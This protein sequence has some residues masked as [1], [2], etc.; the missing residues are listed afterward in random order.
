MIVLGYNGFA[1][2]ADVFSR[3]YGATGIDRN[4][5]YGHDSSAAL[6]VDGELVAAAEEERF[7]RQKRTS[8]FPRQAITWCLKHAGLSLN[9][10]DM[11][12]FAWQ[13]ADDVIDRMIHEIADDSTSTAGSKLSRLARLVETHEK[14]LSPDAR[15]RD[16]MEKTGF[17]LPPDRLMLV[18]HHLC[19]LMTGHVLH[20][21]EDSA[22]LISDGRAEW[23]SSI[24][25]Q[26]VDGQ[27]QIFDDT[28]VDFRNSLAVLYSIV[29]R[30]LGFT[31]NNDEY[32]VMGLAAYGDPPHPNPL[33]GEVLKVRSDGTYTTPFAAHEVASY[34]ELFDRIFGG[35]E[36]AR[37][38]FSY[39]VRVAAAAQDLV[40]QVTHHQV[41]IL[42][43]R[44]SLSNLIFE[45]GLA[46]NCVNN[47]RILEK[48]SY[49]DVHVS[50]GASDVGVSLGA[51]FYACNALGEP[52]HAS[53]SP[54]L[55]PSYQPYEIDQALI[56]HAS[57]IEWRH[58]EN[59][60]EETVNLL[61]KE[62]IIAW[63]QGRMEFGPRA[64]GNRSIIANPSFP[65]IKDT[66]NRKVK[67]R[68]P[69]RPFAP[70]V[71]ETRAPEV[72]DMGKKVRSPYMTFVVP[73]RKKYQ[74]A[75][76]GACHVDMTSRVQTV[77][78]KDNPLLA[79]LLQEF[80]SRT[81]IPCLI[82][83]SFNIAG[84]PIVCSP[85]DAIL[86]FLSTELDYLVLSDILVWRSSGA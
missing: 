46:L 7:N 63:F 56:R 29:T 8:A 59:V 20:G 73:V 72:F 30:Y 42:Q 9:Q 85:D 5:I 38:S 2:A 35:Q 36:G 76:Q 50:F 28:S 80:N 83:T 69:F 3:L 37:E 84:E 16:F 34:Y 60:V 13:F 54:Y 6:V 67:H 39:R 17:S 15:V 71:L 11:F 27:V 47:T 24:M 64:L 57:A 65:D 44:A 43:G 41:K 62:V 70:I 4:L 31:P 78:P 66:I 81:G 1:K 10:V 61:E 12:A 51:A 33:L 19:H 75:I 49:K 26:I 14:L 77:S 55:G 40:E 79:A 48:S 52:V 23:L 45:G 82:N 22:F 68:E 53:T 74:K 58:M 86:C 32:K 18:P 21:C 25:G